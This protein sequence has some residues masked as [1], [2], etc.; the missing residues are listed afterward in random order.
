MRFIIFSYSVWAFKPPPPPTAP[1]LFQQ[2]EEG[3]R[4]GSR[5]ANIIRIIDIFHTVC[6]LY[7]KKLLTVREPHPWQ[8]NILPLFLIQTVEIKT[9]GTQL[10]A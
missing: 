9:R 8:E 1:S 7:Y 3:G 6:F 10:L 2:G 4:A 5:N